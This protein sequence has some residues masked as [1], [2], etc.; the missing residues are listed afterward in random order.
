MVSKLA[1]QYQKNGFVSGIQI[2]S[3][4]EA[5]AHRNRLEHAENQVGALHYKSKVHTI[6]TSPLEIATNKKAKNFFIPIKSSLDSLLFAI[7]L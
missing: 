1:D 3:M 2:I 4:R 5:W 6:L 7:I